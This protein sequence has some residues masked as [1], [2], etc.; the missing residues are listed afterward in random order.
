MARCHVRA[1]VV[2]A[3]LAALGFFSGASAHE[4]D[5][6]LAVASFGTHSG[7]LIDGRDHDASFK[8]DVEAY[9]DWVHT[10]GRRV[11]SGPWPHFFGLVLPLELRETNYLSWRRLHGKERNLRLETIPAHGYGNDQDLN[12]ALSMPQAIYELLLRRWEG[13]EDAHEA[14]VKPL[15]GSAVV[16]ALKRRGLNAQI[17]FGGNFGRRGGTPAYVLYFA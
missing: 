8:A 5:G 7:C 11:A 13:F 16:C 15:F 1:G 14:P 3:L 17:E 2:L 9:A 10:V 6:E 12:D 4:E